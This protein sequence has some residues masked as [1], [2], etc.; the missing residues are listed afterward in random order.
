M[1]LSSFK[2]AQSRGSHRHQYNDLVDFPTVYTLQFYN[3]TLILPLLIGNR[4]EFIIFFFL[5]VCLLGLF[6]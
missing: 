3:I 5:S 6:F 1:S 4:N 2:D